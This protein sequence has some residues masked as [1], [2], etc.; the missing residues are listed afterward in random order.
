[1]TI[2]EPSWTSIK[3]NAT[4]YVGLSVLDGFLYI[5]ITIL[6]SEYDWVEETRLPKKDVLE[7]IEFLKGHFETP[8]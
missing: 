2:K 6:D 3:K 1:M 4:E 8:A 5:S 7:L